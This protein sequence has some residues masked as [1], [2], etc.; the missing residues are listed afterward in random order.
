LQA[1][2]NKKVEFTKTLLCYQIQDKQLITVQQ[3]PLHRVHVSLSNAHN[4]CNIE[5][6]AACFRLAVVKTEVH[7]AIKFIPNKHEEL[8]EVKLKKAMKAVVSAAEQLL[9]GR[10][11]T[12]N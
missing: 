9:R 2:I 12:I 10:N 3:S 7:Q 6:I 4:I 5:A 11:I 1:V 8:F